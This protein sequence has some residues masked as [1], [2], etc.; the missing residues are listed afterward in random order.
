MS[1]IVWKEGVQKWLKAEPKLLKEEIFEQNILKSR[2]VRYVSR[3]CISFM[4]QSQHSTCNISQNTSRH[5]IFVTEK[6]ENI[7]YLKEY[8][9]LLQ[10]LLTPTCHVSGYPRQVIKADAASTTMGLFDSATNT[11]NTQQLYHSAIIT[12]A[13]VYLLSR[14]CDLTSPS[15]YFVFSGNRSLL[16]S[17]IL[18]DSTWVWSQRLCFFL[19]CLTLW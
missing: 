8:C 16:E 4:G 17:S 19:L 15:L 3:L 2:T 6:S 11:Y 1:T 7:F 18:T 10:V 12:L 9:K 5:H 14:R 13:L